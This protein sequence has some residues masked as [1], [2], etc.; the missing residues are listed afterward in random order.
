MHDIDVIQSLVDLGFSGLEARVYLYLLGNS[1][2]TGYNIAKKLGKPVSNVY[3]VI[4][5]MEEKG[6]LLVDESDKR[7]CR[8]VPPLEFLRTMELHFQNRKRKAKEY[9]EGIPLPELDNRVYQLST[10]EQVYAKA[11][12][13]LSQC[14]K[15][16]LIDIFPFPMKKLKSRIE[17]L[18]AKKR[19]VAIHVYEDV[20]IPGVLITKHRHFKR[21]MKTWTGQWLNIAMDSSEL[22][23]AYMSYDD[24]SVI[25]AV[26]SPNP[27]VSWAFHT[28]AYS[29]ILLS[30]LINSLESNAPSSE[31]L[32]KYTELIE[33]F[34]YSEAPH[35][36]LSEDK[37]VGAV[38]CHK[39]KK[40]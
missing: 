31:I 18:S 6:L 2:A 33:R 16:L 23:L 15:S 8:V 20:V 30:A 25:H 22:L 19:T 4:K 5:S 34:P 24:S 35:Q 27:T 38:N 39:E 1:P 17:S 29:D 37:K 14:K 13:M 7:L 26:W 3:S 12:M 36:L 32:E 28:N 9:L 21:I 11:E 10:P 40:K